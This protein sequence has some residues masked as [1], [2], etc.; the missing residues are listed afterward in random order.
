MRFISG[1]ALGV[2]VAVMIGFIILP[3]IKG[4]GSRPT[5]V[6]G[7]DIT[8]SQGNPHRTRR[9]ITDEEDEYISR[10]KDYRPKHVEPVANP[11]G[12]CP[13][14]RYRSPCEEG[15]V[16]FERPIGDPEPVY[17]GGGYNGG[18]GGGWQPGMTARRR[19]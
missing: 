5:Y 4:G 7:P 8:D 10:H 12:G 3:E 13:C 6:P 18:Y 2:I 11:C 17:Y 14:P 16:R 15:P 19:P 9:V 1:L